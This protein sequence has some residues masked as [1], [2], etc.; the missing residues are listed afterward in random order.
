MPISNSFCNNFSRI[1][2]VRSPNT[3]SSILGYKL[4]KFKIAGGSK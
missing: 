2:P 1:S 3:E 4:L